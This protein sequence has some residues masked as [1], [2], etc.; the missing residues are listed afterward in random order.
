M[1]ASLVVLAFVLSG[2]PQDSEYVEPPPT[3]LD[4][5]I[6]PTVGGSSKLFADVSEARLEFDPT[7]KDAITALGLCVDAVTYC[8]TPGSKEVSWCLEHTRTCATQTPWS[9]KPCCPQQCKD[10]FAA[11]VS[12]GVSESDALTQVFF[13]KKDCFPGVVSA[14]EGLP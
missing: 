6:F 1:R 2:C 8:Y 11:K 14:L 13:E 9:E 12:G 10:E 4:F 5:A 7:T 3:P